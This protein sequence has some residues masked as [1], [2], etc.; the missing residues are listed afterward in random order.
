M[1]ER[2]CRWQAKRQ[3]LAVFDYSCAPIRQTSSTGWCHRARRNSITLRRFRRLL[4]RCLENP[5]QLLARSLAASTW[6][7]VCDLRG[8]P[9]T[10]LQPIFAE[11]IDSY[12]A[13]AEL[14]CRVFCL[15]TRQIVFCLSRS[16]HKLLAS[17]RQPRKHQSV[18]RGSHQTD[19]DIANVRLAH[20]H[21]RFS[22]LRLR[23]LSNHPNLKRFVAT[24][25]VHTFYKSWQS[26][27]VEQVHSDPI[28][29]QFGRMSQVESILHVPSQFR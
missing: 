17:D 11:S 1:Y 8:R 23:E 26:R 6:R 19:V 22:L 15:V 2:G 12:L 7:L 24:S 16:I 9:Q 5:W 3:L 28:V 27:C 21:C 20:K 14:W 25:T 29:S 18:V 4:T 13:D 10:L